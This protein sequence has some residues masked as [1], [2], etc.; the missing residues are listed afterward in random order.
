MSDPCDDKSKGVSN[1]SE[2]KYFKDHPVKIVSGKSCSGWNP[3]L[4]RRMRQPLKPIEVKPKAPN[5]PRKTRA[6]LLKEKFR[7]SEDR[8]SDCDAMSASTES[9][10]PRPRTP[11]SRLT[12]DELHQQLIAKQDEEFRAQ[13]ASIKQPSKEDTE[14]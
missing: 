7:L 4:L 12:A 11:K 2:W 3:E 1:F 13:L 10:I 8:D 9:L 5:T 14:S 6:I